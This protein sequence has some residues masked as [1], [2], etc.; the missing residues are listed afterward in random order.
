M[1][2]NDHKPS[3]GS[4]LPCDILPFSRN[5]YFTGKL[6]TER[7]FKAEQQYM[8]D[9]LRLHHVAL[10][11]WGVVCGLKVTPHPVCPDLKIVVEPGLAVDG[12]GREIR[13]PKQK[14]LEIPWPAPSAL[15]IKDPYPVDPYPVDS[16]SGEAE[17]EAEGSEEQEMT[18]EPS[19]SLYVGLRYVEREAEPMPAPF[20][21]CPSGISGNQANRICESYEFE[22]EALTDE[23]ECFKWV[24]EEKEKYDSYNSDEIYKSLLDGCVK[25]FRIDWIPLA[26]ISDLTPGQKVT[27]ESI[28]NEVYRRLLLST[29]A[30][31]LLIRCILD[32]IPTR[33]LTRVADINWTHRKQ[34][35]WHDFVK[36]FLGEDGFEVTFDGPVHKEGI[37][38]K[39]TSRTFQAI[40]VRYPND[41]HGAGIPEVVP[42][43]VRMNHERTKVHLHI[44][45]HYAKNRLIQTRFELYLLLRCN[46]IVDDGGLPVDG[47]LLAKLDR[48]EGYTPGFPTGDGIAGGLFESWIR[49]VHGEIHEGGSYGPR[50]EKSY[51][52]Q[53]R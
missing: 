32:K 37:T 29:T 35:P 45:P 4:C 53:D 7:D 20:N 33:T 52:I 40:V 34:Y 51:P 2:T 9:K 22:V 36:L 6:L 46:L 38:L 1:N 23:P 3:K 8:A 39:D 26:V 12:C 18:D 48:E 30:L 31:D 13:V 47:E 11:G 43:T 24:R 42:A 27:A 10:H 50:T 44:D 16:P 28:D 41:V 19:I 14:E 5:N 15:A 17:Y 25:P 49:V 21:E